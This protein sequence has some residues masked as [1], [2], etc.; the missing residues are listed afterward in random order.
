ML[1]TAKRIKKISEEQKHNEKVEKLERLNDKLLMEIEV[2][3][4][5]I[6]HSNLLNIDSEKHK[7]ILGNLYY[8]GIIEATGIFSNPLLLL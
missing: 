2:L 5:D 7:S 6:D 1:N 8:K 4:R 3:K